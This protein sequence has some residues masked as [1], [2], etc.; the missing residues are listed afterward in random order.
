MNPAYSILLF[1]ISALYGVI[2]RVRVAMYRCGI[3]KTETVDAPVI[4]VGNITAGGTGKTPVVEWIARRL[5]AEG[6]SVCVLTRGYGRD[7]PKTRVLASD[8]RKVR[9]NERETGDEALLLAESL[10]GKAAV[11]CDGNR[12]EAAKWAIRELGSEVLL[13]DDGFQ[14][15]RIARDL[16][17]V[18]VDATLPWG[19][20]RML[21]LGRLREPVDGLARA[22]AVIL[23]RSD[24]VEKI[25]KLRDMVSEL[26]GDAPVFAARTAV[27]R[28]VG[29][30][31]SEAGRTVEVIRGCASL[32]FCGIGNPRS[33]FNQLRNEHWNVVMTKI[34][35]DHHVFEQK[36]VDELIALANRSGLQTL[37]TTTKDAIK[38]RN[39]KFTIECLVIEVKYEFDDERALTDLILKAVRGKVQRLRLR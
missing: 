13:L 12:V 5:A 19:E 30:D 22:D 37:I 11:V 15:L 21:P 38:L 7:N 32:A 18:L 9:G 3:L 14:H 24:Q 39:L 10:V 17:I 26:C 35:R 6:L 36:D 20:G 29:L 16:N 33:F 31:G 2:T 4:S 1:P 27:S 25:D 28:I 23:T 34:F 8:G